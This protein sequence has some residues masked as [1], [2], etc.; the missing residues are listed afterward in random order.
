MIG[1]AFRK[2]KSKPIERYYLLT[3]SEPNVDDA[4]EVARKISELRNL[5]QCQIII[6]GVLPSLKYYMRLVSEPE[7]FV[8]LYTEIL[9]SEFKLASGIKSEHLKVWAEIR[10]T[11]L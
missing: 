9:E 6:N 10:K 5:H 1:L 11:L 2:I 7:R 8:D 3:T 4:K